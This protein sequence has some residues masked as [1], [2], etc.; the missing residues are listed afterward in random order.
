MPVEAA[1]MRAREGKQLGGKVLR[2]IQNDDAP[3]P[4]ENVL[5]AS[6]FERHRKWIALLSALGVLDSGYL[7]LYQ[8]RKVK[9]LWCPGF[10]G[11]C[12]RIAASPKAFQGK[13]P[14]SLL[15]AAGYAALLGLA[16]AGER[17]RHRS[18]PILP[19]LMGAGALAGFGLSA[20]LTYVQKKE[21]DDFCVWCLAS[22][23]I[24][25]VAVPLV[26]PE[27]RAALRSLAA[28]TRPERS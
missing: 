2:V 22:A 16:L 24:S 21:F 20:L 4:P 7:Y 14:D 15:G 28:R 25:T 8:T 18:R 13:V 6:R 27:T 10:G 3:S 9:H 17:G 26:L 12:D 1:E 11:A 19:L 23:A 5:E